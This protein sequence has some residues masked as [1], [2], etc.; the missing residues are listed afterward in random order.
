[1]KRKHKTAL[2]QW[3][4]GLSAACKRTKEVYVTMKLSPL[5]E[6]FVLSWLL[7]STGAT[8]KAHQTSTLLVPPVSRWVYTYQGTCYGTVRKPCGMVPAGVVTFEDESVTILPW[9]CLVHL[10]TT[11][12]CRAM[13][14]LLTA[15]PLAALPAYM[16]ESPSTSRP[17]APNFFI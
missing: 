10:Q 11:T 4:P 12:T 3:R 13:V 1:M 9:D 2:C 15:L 7:P 5:V 8:D 6:G 16:Y 14:M 17:P